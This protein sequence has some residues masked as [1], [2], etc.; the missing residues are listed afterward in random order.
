MNAQALQRVVVRMLYDP[1]LV[2]AVYGGAPVE[3]LDA[4]GRAHLIRVDRRAWATDPYRRSRSL[5][6]LIEEMPVS[7]ALAGI[8]S[9]ATA[10]VSL[11]QQ[12]RTETAGAIGGGAAGGSALP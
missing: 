9:L 6:A 11:T 7:A 5:K 1:A 2:D 12:Q 4:P 8:G 10:T 3:G